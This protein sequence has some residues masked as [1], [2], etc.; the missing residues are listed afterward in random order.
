MLKTAHIRSKRPCKKLA[1]KQ[2][3][4]FQ[5]LNKET[6]LTYQL[7]LKNLVGKI[8]DVFHV[9]K[10]EKA[11]LPQQNQQDYG[12]QWFVNDEDYFESI[13]DII[14]SRSKNGVFEYEVKWSDDSREWIPEDELDGEE[15][16]IQSFHNRNPDRPLPEKMLLERHTRTRKP[17]TR[18]Q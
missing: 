5:I 2:I 7:D 18:Y 17:P 3:G 8:H 1:G 10:L 11:N 9:E 4:P 16:E 12:M 6:D 13:K 14:N 15:I